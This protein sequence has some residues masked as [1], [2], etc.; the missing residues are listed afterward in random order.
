MTPVTPDATEIPGG[1]AAHGAPG[2]PR[3]RAGVA[4]TRE[5]LALGIVTAVGLLPALGLA[6]SPGPPLEEGFMLVFPERVL[7]GDVANRDFLHLYGPGS[8]WVLAAL[9]EVLGTDL[10][11]QRLFGLAQKLAFVLSV[12]FVARG[13]GRRVATSSAIIAA[14]VMMPTAGLTAFAWN[15]ALALATGGVAL[16]TYARHVRCEGLGRTLAAASGIAF[17]ASLLFRPDLVLAVVLAIA[18]LVWG[19]PRARVVLLLAGGAATAGLMAIHLAMAGP[20]NAVEGMFLDPVFRLRAGRRLPLVPAWD[21]FHGYNERIVA[22]LRPPEWPLPTLAASQQLVLWAAANVLAIAFAVGVGALALRGD[23]RSPAARALL[24]A[25]LVALGA[26]PQALQRP[27]SL[28]VAWVSCLSFALIP[29][30]AVAALGLRSGRAGHV[31]EVSPRAVLLACAAPLVGLVL[32]L[33]HFTVR[34]YAQHVARSFG[35]PVE[36]YAIERNGRRFL[37]GNRQ[38]AADAA[39]LVADLGRM[40]RPGDRLIVGPRDLRRTVTS[41]A[42]VYHLFPEAVPGTRY[43]EMDPGIANAAD[44]G[45]ADE[46]RRADFLVLSSLWDSWSEPNQST[47]PGSDAPVEVLRERFCVVGRYGASFELYAPCVR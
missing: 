5:A 8:L 4:R 34:S 9:Y 23:P 25:S 45:L 47:R 15:G 42:W 27:D 44:S 11:V 10:L 19:A 12:Y 26:L 20:G 29:P 36:A 1:R 28:H 43:I 2:P 7:A 37:Y 16:G 6:R 35:S 41:E 22:L 31:G 38:V 40:I 18:V 14:L 46:L 21:G 39:D 17:G 24:A 30:A 3:P 32:V 13:Y 33:P